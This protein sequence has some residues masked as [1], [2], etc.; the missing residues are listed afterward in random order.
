MTEHYRGF[1]FDVLVSF[2]TDHS[3][4]GNFTARP[5]TPEM[6]ERFKNTYALIEMRMPIH[7]VSAPGG[8]DM[9]TWPAQHFAEIA[10]ETID[11]ALEDFPEH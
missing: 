10:R 2:A 11:K 8:V 7:V 9:A 6:V 1:D 4:G 3:C 5:V